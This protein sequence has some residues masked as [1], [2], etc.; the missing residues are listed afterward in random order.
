MHSFLIRR[1][2]VVLLFALPAGAPLSAQD[3]A[4][5]EPDRVGMSLERLERIDDVLQ[6]YIDDRQL[7]GAAL[8]VAR[9]GSIVYH[10]AFGFRDVESGAT[11]RTDDLFRIASQTKALVS[12]GI[13]MLQERGDLLISDPLHAYIP[14]FDSMKVAV[15]ED[16][17]TYEIEDAER[18]ITLRHLLTHTSGIGYGWGPAADLWAEAGIQGWYFA[19]RDE[20]IG[21]TV[22]RMAGLP[23]D[24]QPGDTFVYGYSTDILGGVIERVSGQPLDEF[25][26]AEIL[27]PLRMHDTHFYVPVE[28]AERL[29]TVYSREDQAFSRAPDPG[30]MVGQG[31]YLSGPR[32]S[33]SG[34]AGLVSTPGDYARFL[35]MLRRGGELDGAR[36]LSPKTIE[37]MTVDHLGE[38]SFGEGEGFGLG[39]SVLEDLGSRTVPGS[40]GEYGWGG[41][42]HSS[43]WVDPQEEL[44]VVYMTQVIPAD[45]LDDAAKVRALIYQAIVE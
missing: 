45:G 44:V 12:V 9:R 26:R 29:T 37:L 5:I 8:L 25:L 18:P 21:T 3:L 23:I 40:V 41:A 24:A 14:A 31:A 33:F 19:D 35:E 22:E 34:G 7:P 30:H 15:A 38:V 6:R 13:M 4:A 16:G 17:D 32:K 27:D 20:P 1:F 39:F 36:I 2:I 43:Y 28:D 11:L 10:K 42:Y